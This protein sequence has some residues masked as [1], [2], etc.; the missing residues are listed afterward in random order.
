MTEDSQAT[1]EKMYTEQQMAETNLSLLQQRIEVVQV[2][3][4][5]YRSG[6]VVLEEIEN[7]KEGEEMLM[8]IGGSIF[9]QASLANKDKVLRGI[10]NGVRIEQS[11]S[12]AKTAINESIKKL[13]EQLDSLTQ[14]Y[15]RLYA[16]STQLNSQFQQLAAQMQ[17]AKKPTEEE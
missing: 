11:V 9:V 17:T 5:N 1:L 4:T 13:E 6:L 12:D 16:Y 14:D 15:Q 2:Y 8:N 10:G 7:R 3:L